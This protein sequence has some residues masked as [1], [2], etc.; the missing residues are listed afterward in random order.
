M[1]KQ[2]FSGSTPITILPLYYLANKIQ[3]KNYPFYKYAIIAPIWLGIW[4]VICYYFVKEDLNR[5][6]FTTVVTYLLSIFLAHYLDSYK[7]NKQEWNKYY[8]SLFFVHLIMWY[9]VIYLIENLI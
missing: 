3:K 6:L 7:F 4:N 8:I 5:L 1:I 9:V 2:F